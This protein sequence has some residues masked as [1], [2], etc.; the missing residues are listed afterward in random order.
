L[1]V[2]AIDGTAAALAAEGAGLAAEGAGFVV[3]VVCTVIG[4][5]LSA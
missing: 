2:G 1:A 4:G 5:I 3:E